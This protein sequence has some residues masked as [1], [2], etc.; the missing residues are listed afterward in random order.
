MVACRRRH[1]D[2]TRQSRLMSTVA[3]VQMIQSNGWRHGE[4]VVPLLRRSSA[5]IVAGQ[6]TSEWVRACAAVMQRAG[7]RRQMCPTVA[8]RAR[9]GDG[10]H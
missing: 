1:K 3:T 2:A 4:D 6:A 5:G 7:E 9:D 10:R 8:V